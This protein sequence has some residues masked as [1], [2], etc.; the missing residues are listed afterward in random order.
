MFGLQEIKYKPAT[1]K[2]I[3]RKLV[4]SMIGFF[5]LF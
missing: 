3:S 1:N 2:E 4:L 5:E